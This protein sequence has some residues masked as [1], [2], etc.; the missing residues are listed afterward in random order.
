MAKKK[1]VKQKEIN[2]NLS[3]MIRVGM[4][5]MPQLI[6]LAKEIAE[7]MMGGD[8]SV[9]VLKEKPKRKQKASKKRV[10]KIHKNDKGKYLCNHA[11]KPTKDRMAREWKKVT[12]Q[13]CL[14]QKPQK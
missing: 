3:D 10:P 2:L 11:V 14:T 9:Q 4:K 5:L 12:C 7:E 13:N 8:D 1:E 6:P